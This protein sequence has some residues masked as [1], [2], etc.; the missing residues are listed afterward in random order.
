[1]VK[2]KDE[3]KPGAKWEFDQSVTDAFDDMLARSIPDYAAM[4]GLCLDVGS[5]FV[6]PNT[7]VVDMGCSRGEAMQPFVDRFGAGNRFWG[8][9]VSPPMFAAAATRFKGLSD[10]GVVKIVDMD[11]RD[12]FPP[13]RASLT[14]CVL[15]LQFIP[16]NHRQKIL[17]RV[18][19]ATDPGGALILVEKVLGADAE[20]D[21]M[22]VKR[23]HEMKVANGYSEEDVVRKSA[24]L[25]GVLV[26]V[27]AAWNEDLLRQAGFRS[28]DCFWRRLNFAGW[29]AV[30]G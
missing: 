22:M 20:I 19:D 26:P 3:V 8:V 23:Y 25:E 13:V 16:I 21:G 18:F 27:T 2:V 14:L 30:K 28:V 11:L 10:A 12:R 15:T 7:A 17:R 1:M 9:E 4:R 24:S 6:R 29:V 5:C